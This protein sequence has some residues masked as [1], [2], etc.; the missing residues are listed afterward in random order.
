M[1]IFYST[2][3]CWS[4]LGKGEHLNM[5]KL[6]GSCSPDAWAKIAGLFRLW[7][8][9]IHLFVVFFGTDFCNRSHGNWVGE[10]IDECIYIYIII[11]ISHTILVDNMSTIHC[12]YTLSLPHF[13]LFPI[14]RDRMV[15][16]NHEPNWA[17]LVRSLVPSSKLDQQLSASIGRSSWVICLALPPE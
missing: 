4:M 11:W 7:S 10:C 15:G 1:W 14:S 16:Q 2:I 3:P 5:Y 13:F 6:G 8:R 9:T 17:K 12:L